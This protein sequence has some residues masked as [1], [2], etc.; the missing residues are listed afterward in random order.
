MTN[1]IKIWYPQDL[2]QIMTL[3][4]P[5]T[6]QTCLKRNQPLRELQQ[7]S[8]AP[9]MPTKLT[10]TSAERE[11]CETTLAN[12]VAEA[13]ARKMTKAH[14]QYTTWIKENCAPA[15]PTTLKINSGVNGFKVM[16][17]LDWTKERDI[18]QRWLLWS[19]KA[20]HA[21]KTMEGDPEEN[22]I[23]YFHHWINSKGMEKI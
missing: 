14:V 13:I 15:L 11:A 8:P 21:L 4:R 22:E 2:F 16:D 1:I 5:F 19:E 7:T 6:S 23:S 20:K 9:E 17:P 3:A 18:H 10:G 12:L